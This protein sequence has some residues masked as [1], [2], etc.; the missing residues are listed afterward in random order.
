[1]C[2]SPADIPKAMPHTFFYMRDA[3]FAETVPEKDRGAAV[4]ALGEEIF[5]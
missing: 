2:T 3:A 1:M 5:H 4:V